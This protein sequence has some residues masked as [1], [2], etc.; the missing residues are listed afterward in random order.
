VDLGSNSFHMIV[1][2]LDHGEPVVIDRIRD[3]VQLAA[4]LLRN[5]RLSEAARARGLEALS[6]FGQ[7]LR[8]LEPGTVR[9]VGTNTLRTAVDAA[10]FRAEAEA[11]L[12]WPIEIISGREE[13]RL[14]YLGAA[15]SLSPVDGYSLVIDI[16]GGS[17]ECILGEGFEPLEASSVEVGCVT[18]T[19]RFF[20][21][22]ILRRGR[23]DRALLAA[24]RAFRGVARRVRRLG[25]NRAAG[26]SGTIRSIAEVLRAG[27]SG[28]GTLTMA[29]LEELRGAMFAAGHTSELE[30]AG[31]KP[32][33]RSLLPAGVA[34]LTAWFESLDLDRMEVSGG[35]LREGVLYDLLGRL[36]HE[37]VRDRA[38]RHMQERFHVEVEQAARV[39]R[40]AL[41]GFDRVAKAWGCADAGSRSLLAW[42]A[43]I[44]EIGLSVSFDQHHVHGA[45]LARNVDMPGFS[46]DDQEILAVLVEGHRRKMRPDLFGAIPE[47]Q[48]RTV[49]LLTCLL[50]LAVH[51]NRDRIPEPP[52]R[53]PLRADGDRLLLDLKPDWLSGRPMTRAD[54]E[55]ERQRLVPLGIRLEIPG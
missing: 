54:L 13:A 39:E 18:F 30:L 31:L 42:G 24:K 14:V 2:R 52:L 51:M 38:I 20:G 12:G 32:E 41:D 23:F 17:T 6:R 27:G 26:S 48:R 15:H 49:L 25:W 46:R 34:I 29:G 50:R 55:Q 37:D 4:G 40:T 33:R 19:K 53:L 1:A 47:R 16:G 36:R 3:Q 45:Y 9:A 28:D 8:G 35:A 10:R 43:R 22:G 44:H 7:R 5:G 21:K 11:A